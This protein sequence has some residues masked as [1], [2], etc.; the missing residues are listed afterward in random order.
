[1]HACCIFNITRQFS[2]RVVD[3]KTAITFSSE[4]QLQY[5]IVFWR[6][7]FWAPFPQGFMFVGLLSTS[8]QNVQ[9]FF[10]KFSTSS[11]IMDNPLN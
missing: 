7:S 1:M 5:F 6:K 10:S 8:S 3:S 4:F 2:Q 9:A 11:V